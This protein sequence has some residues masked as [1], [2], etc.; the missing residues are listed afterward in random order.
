MKPAGN[1]AT[2]RNSFH[3]WPK[4]DLHCHLD[5]ALRVETIF[6][7]ARKQK[8]AIPADSPE[9]LKKF[10][11]VSPSCRSL[12]DFLKCFTYFYEV[13]KSAET[14]E[15]ISYELC[16][17]TS[18]ENVRY[19]EPRYA[20][21]LQESKDFHMEDSLKSVL[22]GLSAGGKKFKVGWGVILCIF[23]SHTKEVA[24]ETVRLADKYRNDGV[25]AIDL[26]GDEA[27]YP[28][29]QYKSAFDMARERKIPI[30]CHAGEAAGPES[31]RNAVRLGSQRIGHGVR[32]L[33]D[34][35]LYRELIDRRIPFEIC[36]TSNVQTQVVHHLKDHPL[37]KFIQDGLYVTLNTDDPGVSGIDLTHEYEVAARELGVTSEQARKLVF[38]GIGA[39]FIDDKKK[40]EM[41]QEFEKE[42]AKID[43]A[44]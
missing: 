32:V 13:L 25:V 9:E 44:K 12:T 2:L 42:F 33:E 26:A 16:E 22:R 30:T 29:G 40:K 1:A 36:L 21:A 3:R 28:V 7:I 17:D 24:D 8:I 14:M 39:L 20:P 31:I 15:R 10:V 23:R 27:R 35:A 5:G 11:Q 4:V 18:A 37:P 34:P 43:G 6:Q 41:T 19:F 38:N